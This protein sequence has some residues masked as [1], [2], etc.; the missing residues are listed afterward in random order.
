MAKQSF[1][2]STAHLIPQQLTLKKIENIFNKVWRLK[3]PDYFCIPFRNGATTNRKQ[4][5]TLVS[6]FGNKTLTA[7]MTNIRFRKKS[8]SHQSSLKYR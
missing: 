5:P 2:L 8:D 4:R 3:N 7:N 6:N 1:L